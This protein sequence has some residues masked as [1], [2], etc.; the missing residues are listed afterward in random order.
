MKNLQANNKKLIRMKYAKAFNKISSIKWMIKCLTI[1]AFCSTSFTLLAQ[2]VFPVT[3]TAQ[4]FPPHTGNLAEMVQSGVNKLSA[5]FMLNDVN[6][7]AYQARLKVAI[8]GAGIELRTKENF[9]SHPINLSFGV[10][11]TL[12]GIDLS[13]YFDINNLDFIGY[14]IQDYNAQGGLPPGLYEICFELYDYDRS[15]EEAASNISCTMISATVLDPPVV[16]GPIGQLPSLQVNQQLLLNWERMDNGVFPT[17]YTVEVYEWPY[18]SNLSP[19]Q[20]LIF[21]QPHFT[22]TV[23]TQTSYQMQPHDPP[24]DLGSRYL[25]QV[26][27]RDITLQN[28]FKNNGWSEV[29]SFVFGEACEFPSGVGIIDTGKTNVKVNWDPFVGYNEYVVR[30]REKIA[31]SQWYE[32]QAFFAPH[33]IKDLQDNTTYE[34][35]IQTLCNGKVESDFSPIGTFTTKKDPFDPSLYNCGDKSTFPRPSN[36][37]PIDNLFPGDII[38]ISGF[39][40]K[41]ITA[42]KNSKGRWVGYAD[43]EVGWLGLQFFGR[44]KSLAVNSDREVLDGNIVI[45]SE[46]LKKLPGF[47]SADS[48][49][50]INIG[51]NDTDF[52]GNLPK[53]IKPLSQTGPGDLDSS[54]ATVDLAAQGGFIPYN[55]NKPQ[56][57][58]DDSYFYDPYNPFN[59]VASY[60]PTDYSNP[61]NPYTEDNPFKGDNMWNPY[62][63]FDPYDPFDYDDPSNPYSPGKPYEGEN[64]HKF[65][66]SDAFDMGLNLGSNTLPYGLT[67]AGDGGKGIVIA[68]DNF[69]FTPTGALLNAFMQTTIPSP[70]GGKPTV[71]AFQ[72]KNASFHPGGLVGESKLRLA[73]N[74]SIPFNDKINITFEKGKKT[75]VG[76][77]CHGFKSMSVKGKVEFCRDLMVP[78]DWNKGLPK[79][80]TY[81]T[82]FFQIQSP[83]PNEFIADVSVSPFEFTKLPEWTFFVDR[84][85]FDF[86][87]K[88]TPPSV[89]FPYGYENADVNAQFTNTEGIL[90]RSSPEWEGF[91]LKA[92]RVRLPKRFKKSASEDTNGDGTIDED[93]IEEDN[94]PIILTED[95]IDDDGNL[96]AD[97]FDDD[98]DPI[99]IVDEDYCDN[100]PCD[101][102]PGNGYNQSWYETIMAQSKDRKQIEFGVENIIIDATGVT[103]Y[104]YGSKL[105]DHKD[106][107]IGSWGFG[108]DSVGI[109]IKQNEFHKAYL[110]GVIDVPAFET[111]LGYQCLIQ[112][113]KY[114]FGIHSVDTVNFQA[115]KANL[116]LYDSELNVTYFDNDDEFR[117]EGNFSGIATFGAP[118]GDTTKTDVN[119]D[120]LKVPGVAFQKFKLKSFYPYVE[121]GSWQFSAGNTAKNKLAGFPI[122]IS[123][124]GFLQ[125]QDKSAVEFRI[126]AAVNLVKDKDNGFAGEGNIGIICDINLDPNTNRQKWT[127]NRVVVN[128]LSLD[129]KS[130]GFNLRGSIGWY[131]AMPTYGSGFRAMIEAEF[132][133]KIALGAVFQCGSVEDENG[134][135]FRYWMADAAMAWNPGIA[136]GGSGLALYGLGGGASYHMERKGFASVKIPDK[137]QTDDDGND[138]D[139]EIHNMDIDIGDLGMSLSGTR[140]VPTKEVGLGIKAMVGFGAI[141][142]E[143]FNGDLTFEI[144]FTP[145]WG[146]NR[147]GL[148]G[149]LKFMTPPKL[150]NKPQD[151]P[152]LAAK[153]DL[154]YNVPKKEFHAN[155]KIFVYAVKGMIRGAY[156]F[157][158]HMAG[159]GVIHGNPDEWYVYLGTPQKRIKLNFDLL[160]LLRKDDSNDQNA[161]A[162]VDDGNPLS[163]N[164]N[165][166]DDAE[167]DDEDSD[168]MFFDDDDSDIVLDDDDDDDDTL[169]DFGDDAEEDDDIAADDD[170]NSYEIA[171][172][173]MMLTAYLDF[174]S[175]L[176]PFPP[177]P[178]RVQSILG[179]GD[180]NITSRD[181]PRFS[182]GGGLLLGFSQDISIPEVKFLLFYA[183]FYAGWGFDAMLQN[184]GNE[185]RCASDPSNTE[186]IGIKG[187]YA[188]GQ[189][190]AYLEG[191]IGLFVDIF[192]LKGRFEILSIGAAALLQ[193]QLPNPEWMRGFIGGYYSILG[194][195][196]KGT[197]NFK[198]EVGE[199]CDIIGADQLA[200]IK[201]IASTSPDANS[202][203]DVDVFTVPQV[204]FSMPMGKVFKIPDDDGEMEYYRAKLDT[205]KVVN[206]STGREV[207]GE[208]TWSIK[209]DVISLNPED[210]LDG[211]T[212]H[213]LIV[214]AGVEKSTDQGASWKELISTKTGQPYKQEEEI[215]FTTDE[216]P[217]YIPYHNVAYSYPIVDQLN[218]LKDES[219]SGYIKLK[220]GQDYLFKTEPAFK[221]DPADWN[222]KIVFTQTNSTRGFADFS[223]N[224]TDNQVNFAIPGGNL[225]TDMICSMELINIPTSM[226]EFEVDQNVIEIET[227]ALAN[228]QQ[229]DDPNTDDDE[230]STILIQDKQIQGGITQSDTA[231]IFG[232]HF[233]TSL[234][235]TWLAKMNALDLS[236]EWHYATYLYDNQNEGN[237]IDIFG[238]D[239]EGQE[240]FDQFE[241][242]G[243]HN[244]DDNIN[245]LIAVEADLLNTAN[246]WGDS[247]NIMMYNHVPN[248]DIPMNW[249]DQ[250]ILGAPPIRS[251]PLSQQFDLQKLTAADVQANFVTL[252]EFRT[253][254]VY[255]VPWQAYK[256][257]IQFRPL[258]ATYIYNNQN[259]PPAYQNL[260][261]WRYKFPE[262]GSYRALMHYILPGKDTPNS[263]YF[264]DFNYGS[265]N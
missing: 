74:I 8:K 76:W 233:R 25:I 208:K 178:A 264:L 149:N 26:Q 224:G 53:A 61:N 18:S 121:P 147:V 135:P 211:L 170:S 193:A 19:D 166:F 177:P 240:K 175:K 221:L 254:A 84:M 206:L 78:I 151:P 134:V 260:V 66:T 202:T 127:F 111:P 214:V 79:D 7:I 38:T 158:K 123:E 36:T 242:E 94:D 189:I 159:E 92:M 132:K 172:I 226:D 160:A 10:P 186:P 200:G 182:N 143:A 165:L 34:Y 228:V 31:G 241:L 85:I 150:P 32:D 231:K 258:V 51:I 249:R 56:V 80:S 215:I 157:P 88:K 167:D 153:M 174:G 253:K 181:D 20:I 29:Q 39:P 191:S 89:I 24:M 144:T 203:S 251:I 201:I 146:V 148:Q 131:E 168:D 90:G 120:S 50:K 250:E 69:K 97:L 195:L 225:M 128:E 99:I 75:Y 179:D 2:P 125:Y 138:I 137:S 237:S 129:Y 152:S 64:L 4:S 11:V 216:A 15:N 185:A 245:A 155:I 169:P 73:N 72:L 42:S 82:G 139:D 204:A 230:F 188:T 130:T 247:I 217:D 21:N 115:M 52:C 58:V 187:W 81:V 244:G 199:K 110:K 98:D 96:I 262:Y 109:G 6:E 5:T 180:Y 192:G 119:I 59:K 145:N 142:R 209:G 101:I 35:S 27:I 196:V 184:V 106:A 207:L 164:D 246:S 219:A 28:G 257:N 223:Y 70:N 86:S 190:Y 163:G 102:P 68:L 43:V 107:R 227:D 235:N 171:D 263:T 62:N 162:D 252:H 259:Y 234:H 116:S 243:Y 154:Q 54:Y 183:S 63:T 47:I 49:A 248:S 173:G 12:Q 236:N 3:A 9:I 41:I 113:P 93:D 16:I 100:N 22:K 37:T 65:N 108:I 238:M 46:G 57:G 118:T 161:N 44:F 77:D 17:E 194:G 103:G 91:Y 261:N 255:K 33:T 48:I 60:N 210:V 212:E 112:P 55:P 176:P 218:F 140:Y 136:L 229:E 87:G 23:M 1:I 205:F 156:T 126:G 14:S 133:P 239:I 213:R 197:C 124:V 95:D 83:D 232:L 40:A 265:S 122:T 220:Q 30:Y 222:Q 114:M 198:F 13:Q 141:K 256:D 105:V 45:V 71:L 67:V 117:V 104:I